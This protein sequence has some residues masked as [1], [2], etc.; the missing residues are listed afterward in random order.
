MHLRLALGR[1]HHAGQLLGDV[2]G[3]GAENLAHAVRE[4]RGQH[5][6]QEGDLLERKGLG[7]LA[8]F[9]A[10]RGGRRKPCCLHQPDQLLLHVLDRCRW[11]RDTIR[12]D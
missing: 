7:G 1:L 8:S 3:L 11:K 5:R 12:P 6:L 10:V 2:H 9:P 4:P